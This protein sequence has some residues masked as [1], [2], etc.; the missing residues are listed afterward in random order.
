M[1]R[2][3]IQIDQDKC[4]GCGLCANACQQSAI[5]IIDGKAKLMHENYCDGLGRCLSKCPV[6][7]ISFSDKYITNDTANAPETTIAQPSLACGCP[8][9]QVKFI[10]QPESKLTTSNSTQETHS[11]L[12]QWPVQ[13]KLVPPGA[14]YLKGAKLL[15]AADCTAFANADFHNK[16]IKNHVVL[17]GCPKLDDGEY[18]EKLAEIIKQN[19]IQSIKVVRMEVPCCAGIV[20]ATAKALQISGKVIPWQIVTIATNGNVLED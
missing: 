18:S 15:I 19:D 9:T 11:Q 6:D 1:K 7:A 16:F 4:I 12:R 17:I 3:I 13:I 20:H 5:Q 8:G 14:P 10:E 2:K